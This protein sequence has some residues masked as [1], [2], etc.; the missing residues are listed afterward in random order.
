MT[1]V[2]ISKIRVNFFQLPNGPN[3][4]NP[5]SIERKSKAKMEEHMAALG[6]QFKKLHMVYNTVQDSTASLETRPVE[7]SNLLFRG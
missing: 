3:A 2:V 6:M 7:V 4:N 1:I 5:N